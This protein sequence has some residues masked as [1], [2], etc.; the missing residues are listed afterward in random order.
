MEDA[1]PGFRCGASKKDPAIPSVEQIKFFFTQLELEIRLVPH[2][3]LLIIDV[4]VG[5][6]YLCPVLDY[7]G[8]F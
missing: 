3:T 1:C 7:T 4:N 5:Y 6:L 2:P 8:L